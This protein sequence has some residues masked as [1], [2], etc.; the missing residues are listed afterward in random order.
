ML[1]WDNFAEMLH[2]PKLLHIGMTEKDAPCSFPGLLHS[3][4]PSGLKQ[5]WKHSVLGIMCAVGTLFIQNK[6]QSLP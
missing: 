2:C 1:R 6:K 5:H 3:S 4:Q